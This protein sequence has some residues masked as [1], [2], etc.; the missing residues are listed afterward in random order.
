MD[1]VH[2]IDIDDN[3]GNDDGFSE[4]M[5]EFFENVSANLKEN[6]GTRL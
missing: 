1:I 4:K 6:L 3:G 5:E 2:T